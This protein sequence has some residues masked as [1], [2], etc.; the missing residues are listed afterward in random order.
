MEEW[1][2]GLIAY[3]IGVVVGFVLTKLGERIS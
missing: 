1:L 2:K 3:L